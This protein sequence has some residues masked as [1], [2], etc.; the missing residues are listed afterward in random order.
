MLQDAHP[1]DGRDGGQLLSQPAVH[2]TGRVQHGV[3]H[4]PVSYTHLDVY[5]RQTIDIVLGTLICRIPIPYT[6][7]GGMQGRGKGKCKGN[8]VPFS[9]GHDLSLIHI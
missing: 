9:A 5:K 2:G 1:D 4:V 7:T 6:E 8:G 3:S